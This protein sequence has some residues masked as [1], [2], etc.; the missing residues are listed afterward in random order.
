MRRWVL[1]VGVE[2]SKLR[3]GVL[4]LKR[5]GCATVGV[6]VEGQSRRGGVG[7]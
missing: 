2:V 7:H 6:P 1:R 5:V 4:S 3:V